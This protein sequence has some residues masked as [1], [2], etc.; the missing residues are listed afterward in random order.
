MKR[1]EIETLIKASLG[2]FFKN[3]PDLIVVDANERS[4]S[5]KLA[6]YIQDRFPDWNVDCEYN[7][8]MKVPKYLEIPVVD[9]RSNDTDGTT[10]Y[11]DIIIHKRRTEQNLLVIEI[12]KS[13]SG[14]EKDIRK[15][16]AFL[17]SPDYKY[18]FGLMLIIYTDN[19]SRKKYDWK[20]FP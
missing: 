2:E 15:I 12:K 20:W 10:V 11:P 13:N 5:H 7:R 9:T 4:I 14:V 6:E 18:D 17:E 16:Q 8:D 3:D 19:K 1:S